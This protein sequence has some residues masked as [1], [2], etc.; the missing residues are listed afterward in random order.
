MRFLWFR[1][2]I[3]VDNFYSAIPAL[4]LYIPGNWGTRRGRYVPIQ[5]GGYPGV[6][7]VCFYC[8]ILFGMW[9]YYPDHG[10]QY[11]PGVIRNRIIYLIDIHSRFF[12]T[13]WNPGKAV[14]DQTNA[15]KGPCVPRI[16]RRPV[17]NVLKKFV[18]N[19][20]NEGW[21]DLDDVL[22]PSLELR[23]RSSLRRW[24]VMCKRALRRSTGD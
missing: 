22:C 2:L 11:A 23:L 9:G 8:N 24:K 12:S 20:C 10:I 18:T 14:S 6:P 1:Y 16:I 17:T 13:A 15:V 21:L 5:V 7:F 3:S 19:F 4:S